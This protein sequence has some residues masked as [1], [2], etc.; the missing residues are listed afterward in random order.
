MQPKSFALDPRYFQVIFQLIFLLYGIFFLKWSTDW[1]H[2]S[3]SVGGCLLFK[4]LFESIKQH[5]FLPL[6]GKSGWRF[7]GFSVLI[8][9]LSL[10]LLL[11]TNHWYVSLFAAFLT[12]VSKY[13]FRF[14]HKHFFNPSA[15]G[16]V[17]TIFIT[18]SVWLSPGQWGSN[19]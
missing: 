13:I 16:I 1:I 5:R 6:L 17:A 11:K 10:C 3:I 15:F 12:V 19:A 4:Y 8:S 7:W 2:Y 18:N 14:N 9:A